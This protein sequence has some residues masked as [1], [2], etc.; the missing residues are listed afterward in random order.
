MPNTMTLINAVTVGAGGASTVS[1]TSI[2][3]TYTDLVIKL[4]IRC[5]RGVEATALG[6][7]INNDSAGNNT[8]KLT[9]GT[10]GTTD[11]LTYSGRADIVAGYMNAA[12]STASTFANIEIYIPNYLSNSAKSM[13][14]D[15]A[16]EQ[17]AQS[18]TLGLGA[19]RW[20]VSS[21][22]TSFSFSD[23]GGGTNISQYSTAHLYGI[24]NS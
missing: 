8:M 13:S 4:S 6:L 2:P 17:N 21:P 14:Y 3:A 5:E 11:N 15:F 20:N 7:Y 16:R 18:S 23:I 19:N 10:G 12:S 22:I 9:Y 1:F 24:K